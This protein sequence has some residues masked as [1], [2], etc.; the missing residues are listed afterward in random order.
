MKI[1]DD[2]AWLFKQPGAKKWLTRK[3][4]P[5]ANALFPLTFAPTVT[6]ATASTHLFALDTRALRLTEW[7]TAEANKAFPV[8]VL[9]SGFCGPTAI[10]GTWEGMLSVSGYGM[11]PLPIP[12]SNNASLL[13][14]HGLATAIRPPDLPW[15]KEVVRLFFGH[16]QPKALHIRKDA[17]TGFPYFT[18]DNQ[19]KK[20]A[21]LKIARD[22]DRF[23]NMATGGTSDLEAM[24][25][26]FHCV[27]AWAIQE[28]QQPDSWVDGKPKPRTAPT[29]DEARNGTY[30]GKTF[31]DKTV[32]DE[33]GN[34]IEGHAAMRR[35]DV[36]GGCGPMN[37]F[38]TAVLGCFREVYLERFAAT[39]KARGRQDKLDVIS[40]FKYAVGS[41]VKTMD[42]LVPEWFVDL[43]LDEMANYLDE[44]FVTFTRRM[45]KSPYVVPPPWKKTPDSYNP[46]FGGS[47]LDPANLKQMP[48]LPSG[49]F[50]NPDVG[51][52]WMTFVYVVLMKDIG[53]LFDPSELENFLLQKHPMHGLQDSSDDATLLTNDP[54][55]AKKLLQPS[56][57]YAVL[58]VETPVIYLGD[59]YAEVDGRKAVYPNPIT[60][61]TNMFGREDSAARHQPWQWANAVA[62]RQHVYSSTPMFRDINQLFEEGCK[63]FI[64]VNPNVI[65]G[66]LAGRH[67]GTDADALVRTNPAV[68]HYRVDPKDVSPALLDELVATIP[69]EDFFPHIKHL[70]KVQVS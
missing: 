30:A 67:V 16:A 58:E 32:R 15:L 6:A 55:I 50:I 27:Y 52:L 59:V 11:D 63:R 7:L 19:Y 66:S 1:D 9:P 54:L 8:D 17:S 29:E 36:F 57:P 64:G 38:G 53:A 41:D 40:R 3:R 69:S 56:S 37:Y 70:F 48:G 10:P 26:E 24:L 2:V 33:A 22:V 39:Y 20:L 42:K 46:V 28:R 44:R 49:I 68:L 12:L 18:T 34:V 61:L 4:G 47:P 65:A 14:V 13:K 35:R 23:L 45:W 51:K 31:A 25:D 21:F 5:R 62:A 60:Y 43:L